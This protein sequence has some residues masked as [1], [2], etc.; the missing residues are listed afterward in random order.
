MVA[1]LLTKEAD[2]ESVRLVTRK[3]PQYQTLLS[4]H[5]AA[6]WRESHRNSPVWL[7][8][9]DMAVGKARAIKLKV[10]ALADLKAPTVAF[11]LAAR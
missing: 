4:P 5:A 6:L 8:A 7:F 3:P 1:R 10:W 9:G 2:I 11:A